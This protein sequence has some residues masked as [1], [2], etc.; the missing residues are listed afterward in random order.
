MKAR[1][2]ELERGAGV[3]A[4]EEAINQIARATSILEGAVHH[5]DALLEQLTTRP[6]VERPRL[7]AGSP[8]GRD[9]ARRDVTVLKLARRCFRRSGVV[10]RRFAAAPRL[11]PRAGPVR[12]LAPACVL[13]ASRAPA[14]PG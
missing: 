7:R 6:Q 5:R 4:I 14:R 10:G 12:G 8:P 9:S 3:E 1:Q 11:L 2:S 13:L